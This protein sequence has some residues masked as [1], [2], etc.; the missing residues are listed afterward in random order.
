MIEIDYKLTQCGLSYRCNS[1][2]HSYNTGK[3]RTGI[4]ASPH[5]E[6]TPNLHSA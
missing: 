6:T 5:T 2:W 4:P 3:S 1:H